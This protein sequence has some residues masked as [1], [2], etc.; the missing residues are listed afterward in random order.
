MRMTMGDNMDSFGDKAREDWE[1]TKEDAQNAW[2]GAKD[3]TEDMLGN[4]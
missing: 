3:K 2:D 1:E 4:D